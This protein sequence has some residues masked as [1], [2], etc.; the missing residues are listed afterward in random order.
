M[1]KTKTKKSTPEKKKLKSAL[2]EMMLKI[3]ESGMGDKLIMS[4]LEYGQEKGFKKGLKVGLTIG[5]VVAVIGA[6]LIAI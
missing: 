4:A 2:D 5:F 6:I 3:F 1:T